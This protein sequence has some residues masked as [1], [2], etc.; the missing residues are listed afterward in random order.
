MTPKGPNAWAFWFSVGPIQSG[1]V[2]I[3]PPR[4]KDPTSAPGRSFL[5]GTFLCS[6]KRGVQTQ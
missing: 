3:V 5:V 2:P 6:R 4:T 1:D